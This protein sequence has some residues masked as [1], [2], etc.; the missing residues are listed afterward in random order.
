ME[1]MK[2]YFKY[3]FDAILKGLVFYKNNLKT[4]SIIWLLIIAQVISYLMIVIPMKLYG[5]I[6]TLTIGIISSIGALIYA[7]CLFFMFK[8]VFNLASLYLGKDKLTNLAILKDLLV[9]GLFNIIPMIVF[10]LVIPLTKY[11]NS[12]IIYIQILANIFTVLY[13]LSLFLSIASL[14]NNQDKNPFFIVYQSMKTTIKNIL[15]TMPLYILIYITGQILVILICTLCFYIIAKFIPLT[16]FLLESFHAIVNN[17]ALYLIAPLYIAVQSILIK[18][19]AEGKNDE[20]NQ[21]IS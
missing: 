11:N 18:N 17:L 10:L 5:A 21:Q 3:L 15:K 19:L 20:Q 1:I 7:P 14:V 16:Q 13:Y 8:K 9:L 6:D 12:L 4:Q 2:N